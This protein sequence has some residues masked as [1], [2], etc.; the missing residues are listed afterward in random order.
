MG[1]ETVWQ[2]LIWVSYV[3]GMPALFFGLLPDGTMKKYNKMQKLRMLSL[4]FIA[5]IILWFIVNACV[6]LGAHW[7]HWNSGL[8][9]GWEVSFIPLFLCC[10]TVF[11]LAVYIP[12]Y[13]N[14]CKKNCV[15]VSNY[16][17]VTLLV[18]IAAFVFMLLDDA[19][20]GFLFLPM[21]VWIAYLWI[22][23]TEW[24]RTKCGYMHKKECVIVYSSDVV[25]QH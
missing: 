15:L 4:P 7:I 9:N 21:C 18:S 25:K 1:F 13:Y 2:I 22:S 20:S 11:M 17:A 3:F 8:I 14:P 19:V 12:I 10:L 24:E 5:I 16:L 6:V 23:A